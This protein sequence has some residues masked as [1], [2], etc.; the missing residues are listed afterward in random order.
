MVGGCGEDQP[1]DVH[2]EKHQGSSH[3]V[4]IGAVVVSLL[5]LGGGLGFFFR[6]PIK[7]VGLSGMCICW[8]I[9]CLHAYLLTLHLVYH[10]ISNVAGG[11]I[12]YDDEGYGG[13]LVDL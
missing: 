13:P 7:N 11:R 1:Q 4:V 3:G 8:F 2:Y 12:N 10:R 6:R 5:A 9:S